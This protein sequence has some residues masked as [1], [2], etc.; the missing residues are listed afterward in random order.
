MVPRAQGTGQGHPHHL[1]CGGCRRRRRC[2]VV[3]SLPQK[4]F[5]AGF[6]KQLTQ[7]VPGREPEASR[8]FPIRS[9]SVSPP[10]YGDSSKDRA[11]GSAQGQAE[12]GV[13]WPETGTPPWTVPRAGFL[14]GYLRKGSHPAPPGAGLPPT[15]AGWALPVP[16]GGPGGSGKPGAGR[17]ARGA[18]SCL[19]LL[20]ARHAPSAS[21]SPQ[22][23][24]SFQY[25]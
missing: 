14:R 6:G 9:C 1:G 21:C 18:G 19:S 22:P 16:K 24:R 17:E 25:R 20:P 13:F 12:L 3:A 23:G 8:H 5:I 10:S 4:G 11:S 7:Q 2:A 15:A